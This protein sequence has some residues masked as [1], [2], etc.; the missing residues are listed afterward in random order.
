MEKR[1]NIIAEVFVRG[2]MKRNNTCQLV[3]DSQCSVLGL[4]YITLGS[5][6]FPSRLHIKENIMLLLLLWHSLTSLIT[7]S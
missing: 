6:Q 1:L 3:W 7:E 5:S 4:Y 2:M